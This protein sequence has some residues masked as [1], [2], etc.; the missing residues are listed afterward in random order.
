MGGRWDLLGIL[1]SAHGDCDGWDQRPWDEV[2]EIG[3]WWWLWWWYFDAEECG[4]NTTE[5]HT[6]SE[7][8]DRPAGC[9]N[10]SHAQCDGASAG[11]KDCTRETW[12]WDASGWFVGLW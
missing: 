10:G 3:W 1:G 11:R 12:T 2:G 6:A 5:H 8:C 4:T 9:A 7:R